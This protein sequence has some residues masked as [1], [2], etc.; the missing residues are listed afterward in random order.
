MAHSNVVAAFRGRV[1]NN[2]TRCPVQADTNITSDLPPLP[3]LELQFPVANG[4]QQSIGAPGANVWREEGVCLLILKVERNSGADAWL[5]WVDELAALF[6][7]KSFN[8]V[9]TYAP[10]SAIYDD[11]NEEGQAFQL[12]LAIPYQFDLIG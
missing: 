5:P 7:G 9:Q 8:G 1:T 2:W 11:D 10:T 6:R 3:C 4:W 12:R